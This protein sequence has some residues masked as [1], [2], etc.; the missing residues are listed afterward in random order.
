M[1]VHRSATKHGIEPADSVIAATSGCAFKA[2]LDDETP[3]RELRLGF[4]NSTRLL[5][6]VVLIWDDGSETV[7]HSMKARKQYRTLLD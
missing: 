4:D 5:E 2:P 6:L 7:I 3:Q 1:E